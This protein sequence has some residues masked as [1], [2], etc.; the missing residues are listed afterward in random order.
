MTKDRSTLQVAEVVSAEFDLARR[1]L[2]GVIAYFFLLPIILMMSPITLEHP[3]SAWPL[4][5]CLAVG[6]A[7]RIVLIVRQERFYPDWR[8]MWNRLFDVSAVFLG[9]FW[10]LISA[11]HFIYYGVTVRSISALIAVILIAAGAATSLHPRLWVVRSYSLLLLVPSFLVILGTGSTDERWMSAFIG[12]FVIYL[13]ILEKKFHDDYWESVFNRETLQRERDRLKSSLKE[14]QEF[15][16][17]LDQHANV[18][19]TDPSG[20][21]TYINEKFCELAK[22]RREELLGQDHRILN[23]GHHPKEFFRELWETIQAGKIWQ[24]EVR[25]KAKDGTFFWQSTTIVPLFD[26][27]GAVFQY[28]AIKSD[29]TQRKHDEVVLA[30]Q[31][32]KLAT[33]SKMAA[34]GEMAGGIAHE[35]NSPLA[36]IN[37]LSGQLREL[38][39]EE[40]PNLSILKEMAEEIETTSIRI[41]KIIIALRSFSRHSSEDP[42][43]ETSLKSIVSETL[44]LCEKKCESEGVHLVVSE[45]PETMKIRC[46]PPE[47][48]QV[49]LNLLN[50]AR[51]AVQ[52]L[53]EKWVKVESRDLGGKIE[54]SITDSGR[55]VPECVMKKLFQPFFTTKEVGKGIGLGLGIS[56]RIMDGLGGA[57]FVDQEC[58]NT[59]FVMQIPMLPRASVKRIVQ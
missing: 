59:R 33:A 58:E 47:I 30:Q 18:S 36:T 23:S 45:I 51:D 2:P 54:L 52:S 22:F 42:L 56:K 14:L 57:L 55:G 5:F 25:N 37:T 24:G 31:H 10:G 1:A 32:E 49:L 29:I 13:W 50:N 40:N 28:I 39:I 12:V 19:I 3:A 8:R 26:A 53:P 46:R 38:L 6:S 4:V 7:L 21:I 48:S 16:H 44:S 9:A 11:L 41:A 34:L 20:K 43:I 27:S 15:K 35:I 17:A